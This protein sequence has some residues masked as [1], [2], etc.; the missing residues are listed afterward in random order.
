LFLAGA[1]AA[2]SAAPI[3]ALNQAHTGS[4]TGDPNNQYRMQVK[5]P[6][7]ALLGNSLLLAEDCLMPPVLPAANKINREIEQKLPDSWARVLQKDFPRFYSTKINELP[8]EEGAGLGLGI[9]LLL[10]A[11]LGATGCVPRQCFRFRLPLIVAA[12]WV[13]GLV[14][15]LKMGSEAA[16]RLMLPYYPLMLV[17]FL[18]LPGHNYLLRRRWGRFLA[19]LSAMCVLPAL[20]L[21][22]LRPLWPARAVCEKWAAQHPDNPQLQRMASVY[23][24]YAHRNDLLAP[25]RA[26]LPPDAREIGF[27]AGPND[28]SYSLWRPF[29]Q[30]QVIDLGYNAGQFVKHPDQMEWLVVKENNWE[31]VCG[32]PLTG[33]AQANGFQAVFSTNLVELVSWGGEKWSVLHKEK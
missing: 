13:A 29:G 20:I 33:W 14:Y 10:L 1:A 19:I 2:I 21:S 28:T 25:V 18:Q 16:P 12:A 8:S 22:P 24:A 23:T 17:P 31:E 5:N 15:L 3:M 11:G 6:A 9:F 30:R 26:N 4:W 27:I 32:V 7:A